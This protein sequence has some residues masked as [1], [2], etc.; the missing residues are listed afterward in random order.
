[1]RNNLIIML[2]FLILL[3]SFFSSTTITGDFQLEMMTGEVRYH[4]SG[5]EGLSRIKT[6]TMPIIPVL[7]TSKAIRY[8][9]AENPLGEGKGDLNGDGKLDPV[10]CRLIQLVYGRRL[11]YQSARRGVLGVPEEDYY[12]DAGD[13]NGDGVITYRDVWYLCTLTKEGDIGLHRSIRGANVAA[14]QCSEDQE[15]RTLCRYGDLYICTDKMWIKLQTGDQDG[16][17]CIN[18]GRDDAEYVPKKPQNPFNF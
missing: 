1:M 11:H 17:E 10:D 12:A 5:G 6:S 4:E 15:G 2:T 8:Y 3:I 9:F 18:Q 14:R 16:M 7:T 13:I